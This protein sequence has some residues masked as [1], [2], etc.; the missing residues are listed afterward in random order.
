VFAV[1]RSMAMSRRRVKK[2]KAPIW[3]SVDHPRL[4]ARGRTFALNEH[5]PHC[6]LA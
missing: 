6:V 2:P 1:P 3:I 4:A 5:S